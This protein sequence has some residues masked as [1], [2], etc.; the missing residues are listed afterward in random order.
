VKYGNRTQSIRHLVGPWGWDVGDGD[1]DGGVR[2]END[3]G[4]GLTLE[5]A[6]GAVVRFRDGV[7][8]GWEVLWDGDENGKGEG[9]VKGL[10]VSLER[11]WVD[12]GADGD[13]VVGKGKENEQGNEKGKVEG[14]FEVT[15]MND[16]RKK[17]GG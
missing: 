3:G 15:T 2:D 14:K 17:K 1:E 9:G 4:G 5:G 11:R 10:E 7:E 6:E 16:T 12:D 13:D 8:G